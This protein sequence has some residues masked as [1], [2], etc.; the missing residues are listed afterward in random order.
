MKGLW[1]G[2]G[3]EWSNCGE[4]AEIVEGLWGDQRKGVGPVR[5]SGIGRK[6]IT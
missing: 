5:G 2:H 4:L 6:T 1:G 3:K